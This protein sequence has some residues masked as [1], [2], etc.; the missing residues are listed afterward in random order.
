MNIILLTHGRSCARGV[1]LG[2]AG[3]LALLAVLALAL[4]GAAY[5]A[6]LE[7]GQRQARVPR[8]AVQPVDPALQAELVAQ[9]DDLVRLEHET[10]DAVEGLAVRLARLQ[11][12]ATRV[13]A[14]G[15][16]LVEVA[17]LDP[18]EFDFGSPPAQG[19]PSAGAARS[20]ETEALLDALDELGQ[21]LAE[22]ERQLGILAG[23]VMDRHLAA[24]IRPEGRPLE[25][26]WVTS[27]Y[28]MRTDPF[29]GKEV[30]HE[31]IDFSGREGDHILAVAAGIV[32]FSGRK[33]GYG[34][35]VEI[36]HGNGLKTR[37]AHNQANLVEV[38]DVAEKGQVVALLGSTGRSTG[39]HV[40]FEV[41][42][43]GKHVNP[44]KYLR[45]ASR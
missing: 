2:R 26:G 38:G 12:Q 29:T 15:A 25:G 5:Y 7:A 13:D 14:V 41:L 18:K 34:N 22:R 19:G 40:H 8:P 6:G 17:G 1:R 28:G 27:G 32:T 30:F 20:M 10:R 42:R 37:Y 9:R 3:G 23:V 21:R 31:G 4:P 36:T 35:L 45:T 43:N 24:S 16:R 11:A 39:P 44:V 33:T